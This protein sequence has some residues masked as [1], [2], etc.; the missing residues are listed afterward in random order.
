MADEPTGNLDSV[1]GAHVLDLLITLNQR[2]GTTLVLVTHDIALAERADRVVTM[3]DGLIVADEL[4]VGVAQSRMRLSL[5][6]AG[7][8]AWR[9]TRSSLTK[10]LFVVFA[11]AIG[12]GALSGVRGFSESV[13]A[14]LNSESRSIMAAD[15]SARQFSP[16]KTAQL[17]R[18]GQAR[19][20]RG[21]SYAN[22][23]NCFDGGRHHS[24]RYARPGLDQSRRSHQVSL[25]RHRQAF[26]RYAAGSGAHARN[27]RRRRRRFDP[28]RRQSR[29]THSS[30]LG[31][32][33]RGRDRSL[34]A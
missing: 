12:V 19:L 17:V 20:A 5:R 27:R 24:R 30:W 10:F 1:N 13:R 29:R 34:R 3:R 31:G 25:L 23:R 18:I 28:A 4:R 26:S 9:E 32:L 21:R 22:H 33:S 15:L 11:V 2:E 14:M 6:T 8:I 7:R 16:P